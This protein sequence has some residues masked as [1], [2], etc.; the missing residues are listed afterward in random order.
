MWKAHPAWCHALLTSGRAMAVHR[1]AFVLWHQT[2]LLP[3]IVICHQCHF[4]PC[5]NPCHLRAGTQSDNARDNGGKNM[6]SNWYPPV[7]LPDGR[8]IHAA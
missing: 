1:V 8:R 2:L 4:G 7:L 5:C 6:C 3:G